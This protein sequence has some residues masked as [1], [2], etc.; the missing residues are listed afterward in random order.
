[1]RVLG[2]SHAEAFVSKAW[3]LCDSS[4]VQSDP[5]YT[6]EHAP[7]LDKLMLTVSASCR[8]DPGWEQSNQHGHRC[9]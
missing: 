9:C 1:M 3:K 5:G 2:L 6:G 7:C 8:Y 4:A